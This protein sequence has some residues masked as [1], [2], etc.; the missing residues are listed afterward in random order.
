MGMKPAF[1]DTPQIRALTLAAAAQAT[2]GAAE[3][4]RFT[5]EGPNW[6]AVFDN[7]AIEKLADATKLA[8]EASID[9]GE[10]LDEERGQLLGALAR[11]LEGWAG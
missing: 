10:Q 4:L 6:P 7:E 11:Y 2:E 3:M 9:A 8:I 1:A 5:R